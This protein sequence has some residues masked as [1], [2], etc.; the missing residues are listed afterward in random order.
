MTSVADPIAPQA[1]DATDVDWAARAREGL[2][3]LDA[4]REYMHAK[5]ERRFVPP[6]QLEREAAGGTRG[7]G[8]VAAYLGDFIAI[9]DRAQERALREAAEKAG[10]EIISLTD[11]Q[12][13]LAYELAMERIKATGVRMLKR[14]GLCGYG[15]KEFCIAV[16]VDPVQAELNVYYRI[17]VDVAVPVQVTYGDSGNS[18]AV[19]NQVQESVD[20]K[21]KP[22]LKRV[23]NKADMPLNL[24]RIQLSYRDSET[25]EGR[26]LNLVTDADEPEVTRRVY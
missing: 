6:R 21:V 13:A 11:E 12:R 4:A 7:S 24:E 1:P 9:I 3:R 2:R 23:L 19:R 8:H 15:L 14:V 16:G 26:P 10:V 20:A 25:T 22:V 5:A 18:T 17:T